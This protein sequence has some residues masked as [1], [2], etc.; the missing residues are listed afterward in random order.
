MNPSAQHAS[1]V[2]SGDR[3]EFGANWSRFLSVLNEERIAEAEKSL[4]DDLRLP[5]LR[6]KTFLDI[7]CGSGLFSLA[8]RRLGARVRSFDFDPRSVS[9]TRELKRRYF[10]DDPSW[11]IGEGSVLDESF[12]RSLGSFDI[13]YSWGVLHHTG[14]MWKAMTHAVIPVAPGGSFFI[15]IYNDQGARSRLWRRLKRLYCSGTPG[16]WFV[17]ALGSAYFAGICL[18]EDLVRLRNPLARYRDYQRNRGM[19]IWHDWIDWFGGYPFEVARPGE[20]VDFCVERGFSRT[21]IRSVGGALGCN[22]FVFR[23]AAG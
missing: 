13:V 20:I 17:T 5:D 1:E 10:P 9:C 4:R 11:E 7:G 12:L 15:A 18:K 6:G 2:A 16:R 19:S 14:E 3:F 8:A 23:R 22:E 21:R